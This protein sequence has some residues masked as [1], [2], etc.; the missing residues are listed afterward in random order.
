MKYKLF[1]IVK[2]CVV[3]FFAISIISTIL[4]R[5][6]PIPFTPLMLIRSVEYAFKGEFPTIKYHWKSKS[7]ISDHVKLAVVAA[8]DQ[9]FYNHH[10]FDFEAIQKAIKHNKR[11]STRMKGGSTISQQCAKNVFLWQGRNWIRKGLEVYFTILIEIFWSKERILEVY[12][13]V[14]EMGI[15]V[16][17]VEAAS[18]YYFNKD[19][20]KLSKSESALLAS[21]LPNPRKLDPKRPSGHVNRRKNW[22]ERQM[23]NLK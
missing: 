11:N 13:N 18:H 15:G 17:G 22:I 21:I 5:F 19:A 9:K 6:I 16:Y 4:F 10:G 12:L 20:T 7:K 2:K 14:I 8:E 1:S 23:R 3:Y